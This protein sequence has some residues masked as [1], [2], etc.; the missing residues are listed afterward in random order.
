MRR[1]TSKIIIGQIISKIIVKTII[2][3]I[4][5]NK[6]RKSS[7]GINLMTCGTSKDS[8][9]TV[10]HKLKSKIEQEKI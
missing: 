5:M 2:K 7:L 4:L 9:K 8:Y 3:I 10:K 1:G 6:G